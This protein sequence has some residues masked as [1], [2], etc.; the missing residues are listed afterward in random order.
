MVSLLQDKID[1]LE[2]YCATRKATLNV[3]LVEKQ[4]LG[5]ICSECSS[6][7][8]FFKN[9]GCARLLLESIDSEARVMNTERSGTQG[10]PPRSQWAS[11][12]DNAVLTEVISQI[13]VEYD[14]KNNDSDDVFV[15]VHDV[16]R[17]RTH[18]SQEEARVKPSPI[19]SAFW[20]ARVTRVEALPGTNSK[21]YRLQIT[22]G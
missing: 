2:V 4:R 7:E 3:S 17:Q 16:N 15:V 12:D 1:A 19:D 6:P 22:V 18:G 13:S 5:K 10:P 20:D 9:A 8:S 11:R 21:V 14:L